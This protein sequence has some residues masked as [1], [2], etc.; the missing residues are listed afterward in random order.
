[1]YGNWAIEF[2]LDMLNADVSRYSVVR[3]VCAQEL[4]R[5]TIDCVSCVKIMNQADESGS[6]KMRIMLSSNDTYI[7]DACAKESE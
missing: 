6:R 4:I 1:M 2:N 5:M 7:R 3:A